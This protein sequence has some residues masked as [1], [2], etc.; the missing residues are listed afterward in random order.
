MASTLTTNLSLLL[1]PAKRQSGV[2]WLVALLIAG[3]VAWMAWSAY[4]MFNE[5]VLLR[6][7]QAIR[8]ETALRERPM[9]PPK[10][11]SE[12]ERWWREHEREQAF[13]WAQLLLGLERA[14][15]DEI[16]LLELSPDKRDS[17]VTL[18][19]LAKSD[20]AL[21]DYLSRLEKLPG[22]TGVH[23][24]HQKSDLQAG[25]IAVNFEIKASVFREA[26]SGL[27]MVD[28]AERAHGATEAVSGS[29]LLGVGGS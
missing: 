11:S 6:E 23:L 16:A 1:R 29:A 4:L 24:L 14:T 27:R 8:R 15:A 3:V 18:R 5:L 2:G 28:K 19:G 20:A 7:A 17:V 10:L 12:E 25:P 22:W 13:P 9:P 26:S 21:L